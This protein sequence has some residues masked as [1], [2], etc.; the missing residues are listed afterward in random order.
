MAIKAGQLIHVGNL[1]LI[2]RIQTGGPGN[3]N[4]PTERI[5][6]LGNHE[7]V[8][9]IRD[10]PDLSF[11]AESLD[12]SAE[13]EA[14]LVGGD[15]A[16]DADGTEYDIGTAR[17]LDV[18]SQFK[19]E[20]NHADPYDV[21]ASAAIPYLTLEQLSYRFGVQDNATQNAT[22]RGDSVFYAGASAYVQ[23]EEGTDTAN[24][25]VIFDEPPI[26]YNGDPTVG[27]R[28][29]LS[30]TLVDSGRR[31][32][33]QVDYTE[34]ATEVTIL[35]ATT[36]DIRVVYQS[37]TTAEYPQV[38]HAAASATRPA[39]LKGR[40]IEIRVGGT[41]ITDRWSSVQSVNVDWRVTLDRDE[42]LGSQQ[43][44]GQDFDVPEVTGQVDIRPRDPAE[45]ITRIKQIAGVSGDEVVGALQAVELPVDIL[46]HSPDDGAVL[47]TLHVPDARFT[48]PGYSG[49]VQQK[50]EVQFPFESDSGS[51]RV[52]KGERP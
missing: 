39:A 51:L 33:P 30:V 45:L 52:F 46:L 13:F 1:V 41:A 24:Q 11:D 20:R 19:N 50:L 37:L 35:E 10:I 8:A 25:E 29:A 32:V 34:T 9:V 22:L 7:S 49:Q 31:L 17:V 27:T 5:E 6:E 48:L 28:H 3:L 2:N 21:A 47:K 40:D 14:L 18:V 16:G 26:P 44:V 12:A 36:S 42:E 38:S 15:Y 4:I 23:V 43:I